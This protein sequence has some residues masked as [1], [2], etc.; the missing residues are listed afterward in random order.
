MTSKWGDGENNMNDNY[1][2]KNKI[3]FEAIGIPGNNMVR[4]KGKHPSTY[5]MTETR[6]ASPSMAVTNHNTND[7]SVYLAYYDDVQGQ[8]RFR[9]GKK[10]YGQ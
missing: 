7:T 6:F 4:V 8:I 9:Y 10:S 3:R 2:P 5:T 1:R